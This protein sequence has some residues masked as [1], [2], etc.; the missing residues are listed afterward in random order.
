[1]II[2]PITESEVREL[3]EKAESFLQ[4]TEVFLLERDFKP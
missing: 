1:M 3:Q 4:K 2:S